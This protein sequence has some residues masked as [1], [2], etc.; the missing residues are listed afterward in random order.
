[1]KAV[2]D[3]VLPSH[4]LVIY[5]KFVC[6]LLILNLV[7]VIIIVNI[8]QASAMKCSKQC[9]SNRLRCVQVTNVKVQVSLSITEHTHVSCASTTNTFS[10]SLTYL[11]FWS[12]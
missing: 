8:I 3:V 12:Y 11:V 9:S 7:V 10:C 4:L 6:V 2:A 5:L 1:M